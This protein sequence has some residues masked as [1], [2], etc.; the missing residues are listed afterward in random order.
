[1]AKRLPDFVIWISFGRRVFRAPGVIPAHPGGGIAF[2]HSEAAELDNILVTN[3]LSH[4]QPGR[5]RPRP[6]AASNALG[7][8]DYVEERAHFDILGSTCHNESVCDSECKR[9]TLVGPG[10]L[11][12]EKPGFPVTDMGIE[13]GPS[14]VA[15]MAGKGCVSLEFNNRP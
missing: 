8:A 9:S 10:G 14:R 13:S 3:S 2:A 15:V 6:P 4:S 1:M 12:V 5:R 7:G 11:T